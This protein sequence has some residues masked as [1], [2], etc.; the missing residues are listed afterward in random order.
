MTE[1]IIFFFPYAGA[2]SLTFSS[3]KEKFLPEMDCIVVDY[4]GHGERSEEE[5]LENIEAIC[6]DLY[7]LIKS[8]V[9]DYQNYYFAGHCVGVL[10]AYELFYFIKGRAEIKMPEALFFSGQGSPEDVNDGGITAM[11]DKQLLQH[12]YSLG[13]LEKEMLDDNLFEY[14]Q[15]LV[16]KLVRSDTSLCVQYE[17]SH[18]DEKINIPLYILNGKDDDLYTEE[19]IKNWNKYADDVKYIRFE[20]NHYFILKLLQ[21]YVDE[22]KDILEL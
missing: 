12:L 11:S 9:Q 8:K 7:E 19:E 6:R 2:S 3:M 18:E 16:L 4:E 14:V 10:I 13:V 20:G 21:D 5:C 22:I 1:N 17:H 15:E